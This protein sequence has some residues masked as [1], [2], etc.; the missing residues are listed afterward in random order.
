MSAGSLA[1]VLW[2]MDGTL[3]DSE[4]LWFR[5]EEALV[6]DRGTGEWTRDDAH[7]LIGVDLLEGARWLQTNKG[8]DMDAHDIVHHMLNAVVD[9]MEETLPWRPGARELLDALNE[10]EVPCV[11]VTMSWRPF[12]DRFLQHVP[13]SFVAT[14]TGEEV[15]PGKG[16]PDPMPYLVAAE[17]IGAAPGD[18]VAIEDSVTGTTSALR[19]GC[20]V[21]GVP[22]PWSNTT[23]PPGVYVRDS[24]QGAT[25]ATL[26]NLG[27]GSA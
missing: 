26:K 5:A 1:G 20:R 25:V 16:K 6:R 17:A 8:V 12:A 13:D 21:L 4:P 14:V 11:L 27:D 7:H 15:P 19:A 23:F 18:C 24:L 22:N 10:A 9:Q 3:I 2:D